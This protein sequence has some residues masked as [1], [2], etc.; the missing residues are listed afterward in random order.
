MSEKYIR[1]NK[2]SYSIVKN[3]RT[4]AKTSNLEDAIFIRDLLID[5]N[6]DLSDIPQIIEKDDNY[7]VLTV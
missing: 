2:T 1:Q 5:S 3:S 4:L 7:L 6:W